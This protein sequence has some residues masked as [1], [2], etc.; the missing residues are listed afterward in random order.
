MLELLGP[1]LDL[2]HLIVLDLQEKNFYCAYL[3]M[4]PGYGLFLFCGL[5]SFLGS[6][7]KIL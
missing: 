6:F 4:S 1:V 3:G 7:L 2:G 5:V